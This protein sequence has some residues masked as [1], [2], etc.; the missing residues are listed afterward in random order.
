MHSFNKNKRKTEIAFGLL[1]ILAVVASL[2]AYILHFDYSLPNASME[3]DL[4]FLKDD[5]PGQKI[6]AISS[7]VSGIANL[8]L[9][10]SYLL[11]F[12][13]FQKGMHILNGFFILIIS[14]AFYLTGLTELKIVKETLATGEDQISYLLSG[15]FILPAIRQIYFLQ[16]IGLTAIGAF[17]TVLTISRFREV[18]F[19]VFGSTLAFIAG[20]VIIAFTWINPEHILLTTSLAVAWTG[21]LIIGARLV[22]RGLELLN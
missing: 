13:R 2:V 9:L 17:A 19:P 3:E 11:L 16:Q 18:R 6:S 10:P 8:I 5:L 22:N 4:S 20:P 15:N 21:L 1:L 14:F 12:W 7:I